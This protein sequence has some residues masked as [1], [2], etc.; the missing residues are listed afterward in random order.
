M[1]KSLV[2]CLVMALSACAS[3]SVSVVGKV[4]PAVEPKRVV[5]YLNQQPDCEFAVIA[6]IQV[7]GGYF[8]RDSLIAG[9]RQQAADVGASVV[10]VTDVQ[11]VGA[12]EY[13]GSAR[14]LKCSD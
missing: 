11:R 4:Y 9:M 1:K 8:K 13:M 2:G 6:H 5:V 7:E 14:A 12:A 3:H 10:E